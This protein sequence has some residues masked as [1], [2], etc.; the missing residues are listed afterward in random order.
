[1]ETEKLFFKPLDPR[2]ATLYND[3]EE[4]KIIQKLQLSESAADYDLLVDLENV[5]KYA[6]VNFKNFSI[7]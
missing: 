6:Y 7:M 3:D 2:M 5:R 1:M 4:I